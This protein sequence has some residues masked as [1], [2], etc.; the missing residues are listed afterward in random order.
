VPIDPIQGARHNILLCHVDRPSE[1]FHPIRPRP[2]PRRRSPCCLHHSVSHPAKEE[3]ICLN[4]VLDRM[5]MQVFVREHDTMIAASV[6]SDVDGIPKGAHYVLLKRAN[7]TGSPGT[8]FTINRK[9]K[10]GVA[11]DVLLDHVISDLLRLSATPLVSRCAWGLTF[12]LTGW[13]PVTFGM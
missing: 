7:E 12:G 2:R 3:G 1:G 9:A 8:L 6:Q 10:T 5:T 11:C 4:E 13:G